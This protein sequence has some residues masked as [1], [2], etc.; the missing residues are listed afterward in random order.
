MNIERY[1][2]NHKSI[3]LLD[4]EFWAEEWERAKR[5]SSLF[6]MKVSADRWTEF[7][8]QVADRYRFR[9]CQESKIV[10]EIIGLLKK[11]GMATQ[12]SILLDIGCGPGTFTL[13]LA[14][15][16]AHVFALDPAPKMLDT[17]MEDAGRQGLCNITPLCQK[18]EVSCFEREFDLVLASF[19]PAIRNA[20]SLLKMHRAS[21]K[22]CCL[23]TSSGEEN[24]K[25]RDE[26]WKQLIGEPF[27]S[28]AFH[29]IYPF[30][31]LYSCGIRPQ[32]CSLRNFVCDDEP[33]EVLID[34]YEKYFEM[35]VDLDSQAKETI[36]RYLER[37]AKGGM[38]TSETEKTFSIMWWRAEG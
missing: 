18:W 6:Q 15:L 31:Y 23:I 16:A 10:Q 38:V 13:P 25:I 2:N 17:L 12:E 35:F 24:F 36:R 4:P 9:F 7:W 28:N 32:I 1:P 33:V 27:H 29:I 20:E 21:R 11:E 5:E 3:H 37:Q 19:S 22:Y 34:W 30:N 14:R 8:N 26:L